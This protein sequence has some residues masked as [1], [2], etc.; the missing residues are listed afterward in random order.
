M[1]KY[2]SIDI[3]TLGLDP[4]TCDVIEFA[5]VLED[6]VTPVEKLQYFQTYV[7]R[8]H[9]LYRGEAYAMSMNH[10][11]IER[12]AKRELGYTYSPHDCLEHTFAIWLQ[13]YASVDYA[14]GDKVIVMGKNF[15]NFDLRFLRALGFGREV[16]FAHRTL[17][18]GSM[19]FR[20]GDEQLPD[21][22]ECLRRAKLPTW[23]KH[24]ALDDARDVIRLVRY[25]KGHVPSEIR[26]TTEPT[27]VRAYELG[28][29]KTY[30][31]KYLQ[32][33][34]RIHERLQDENLGDVGES[35]RNLEEARA[36]A[37]MRRRQPLGMCS[38]YTA[39]LQ[40]GTQVVL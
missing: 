24:E 8:P 1:N 17:D 19:F 26:V 35:F 39:I 28:D 36:Y 33:D 38:M 16:R 11:I 40:D 3:E 22:E 10:K 34:V 9:N 31:P 14:R 6:F 2:V 5:A 12:I 25:A 7:T 32:R 15:A 4:K 18:P 37:E 29:P 21:M 23:V 20:I 30:S 13:C 27:T